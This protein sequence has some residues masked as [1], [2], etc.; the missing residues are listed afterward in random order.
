MKK[1]TAPSIEVVKLD[2]VEIITTS[3]IELPEIPIP[4]KNLPR[5]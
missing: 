4:K 5:F 3:G 2:N 1:Y